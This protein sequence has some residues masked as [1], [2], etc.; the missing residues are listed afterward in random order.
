MFMIV[1]VLGNV[2]DVV[3][4]VDAQNARYIYNTKD[5]HDA[6]VVLQY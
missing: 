6:A 2:G 5:I 3:I 4:T 1:G